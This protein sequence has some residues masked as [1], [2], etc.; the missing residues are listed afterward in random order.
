MTDCKFLASGVIYSHMGIKVKLGLEKAGEILFRNLFFIFTDF[1][2]THTHT[3]THSS[4]YASEYVCVCGCTTL[5]P[6]VDFLMWAFGL[7]KAVDGL[8]QTS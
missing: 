7:M 2:N 1:M 5:K 6:I 4:L 3:H 8:Q